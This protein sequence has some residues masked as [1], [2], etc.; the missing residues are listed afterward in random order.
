M[1]ITWQNGVSKYTNKICRD[2]VS[3]PLYIPLIL[4]NCFLYLSLFIKC[5]RIS[6]NPPYGTFSENWVWCMVDKLYHR[7]NPRSNLRPIVCLVVEIQRFVCDRATPPIIDGL[8]VLLCTR[9]AFPHTIVTRKS[10]KWTWA[11]PFEMNVKIEQEREPEI[12]WMD[13]GGAVRNERKDQARVGFRCWQRSA[14]V[15]R[16]PRS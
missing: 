1:R 11:E 9:M 10:I 8:K 5:D 2:N 7:A 14:I 15:L 4:F 12:N 3:H 13:L 16:C 6:E